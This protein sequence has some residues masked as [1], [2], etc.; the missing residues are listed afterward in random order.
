MFVNATA[1]DI[2]GGAHADNIYVAEFGITA[3]TGLRTFAGAST[4]DG[5]AG[6]DTIAA[7]NFGA[8]GS[9]LG[10]AGNDSIVM[11]TAAAAGYT[12]IG[13][14]N[15]GAGTDT[16]VFQASAGA[17]VTAG[18]GT[19]TTGIASVAYAAGDVIQ[20]AFTAGGTNAVAGNVNVGDSAASTTTGATTADT[21]GLY[22]FSDGT[23]TFFGFNTNSSDA[24]QIIQFKVTGADLIFTTAIDQSVAAT[25]SRVGFT[26][27]GSAT[28]GLTI[29][30]L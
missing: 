26:L 12:T 30:L 8:T 20:L 23:D 13:T 24:G 3:G 4:I 22:A 16:I 27:A 2:N 6:A 11:G 18:G 29:T 17:G 19:L 7:L 14:I 15:G 25:T 9:I 5:G 10:G 1:S 21:G 28:T